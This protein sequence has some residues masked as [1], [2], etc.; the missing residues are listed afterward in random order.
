VSTAEPGGAPPAGSGT[1]DIQ[2]YI[3][4]IDGGHSSS[5]ININPMPWPTGSPAKSRRQIGLWSGSALAPV[6]CTTLRNG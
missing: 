1:V 2:G 5:F 6:E 3:R 4:I